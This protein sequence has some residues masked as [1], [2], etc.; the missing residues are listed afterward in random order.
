MCRAAERSG[1]VAEKRPVKLRKDVTSAGIRR[2]E[3]E[4]VEPES[5][6]RQQVAGYGDSLKLSQYQPRYCMASENLSKLVGL[7]T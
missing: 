1:R 3:G 4:G 5:P 6:A 7:V 2:C